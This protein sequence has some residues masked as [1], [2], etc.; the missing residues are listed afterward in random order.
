M[1]KINK[2]DSIEEDIGSLINN[3][4]INRHTTENAKI[5][6]GSS[7]VLKPNPGSKIK[8]KGHSVF[9]QCKPK[10]I[11]LFLEQLEF[12]HAHRGLASH[13]P[14]DNGVIVDNAD[15]LP[16]SS[17]DFICVPLSTLITQFVINFSG[18]GESKNNESLK[19]IYFLPKGFQDIKQ[20]IYEEQENVTVEQVF[21]MKRSAML[22][23]SEVFSHK[24]L[25][26]DLSDNFQKSLN[27]IKCCVLPALYIPEYELCITGL[28]SVLRYLLQYTHSGNGQNCPL[29]GFQNACLS[30]PA[31]VSMWTRFCEIDFP[32]ATNLMKSALQKSIAKKQLVLPDEFAKFEMHLNQ[33]VRMYNIRKRMQKAKKTKEYDEKLVIEG[34]QD[35][36]DIPNVDPIRNFALT[37]HVYAEGP[38]CLLSDIILFLHYYLSFN[39]LDLAD[40]PKPLEGLLPKTVKWFVKVGATRAFKVAENLV[41]QNE[42]KI[43][44]DVAKVTLP[45]V[46]DQSLYKSDPKRLNTASRTFTRSTKGMYNPMCIEFNSPFRSSCFICPHTK[47]LPAY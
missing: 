34:L 38:D 25:K 46:P 15:S 7:D 26:E 14:C 45:L 6:E 29:L 12:E 41:K 32:K 21:H 36:T 16:N 47:A 3:L 20:N 33:P 42:E 37:Q 30:A 39:A 9:D 27:R 40:D 19:T 43:S 4:Q 22:S 23:T 28:C 13:T 5:A 2:V 24:A 10:E 35:S 11:Q 44:V 17:N 31:E 1:D 18:W 8:N